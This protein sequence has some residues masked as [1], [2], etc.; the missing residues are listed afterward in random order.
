MPSFRA[1]GSAVAEKNGNKQ[2]NIEKYNIGLGVK[3]VKNGRSMRF[4]HPW[5]A[6]PAARQFIDVK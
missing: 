4:Y 5:L 2:T 6:A 3:P 1:N